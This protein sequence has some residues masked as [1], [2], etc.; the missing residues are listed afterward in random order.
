MTALRLV[1]RGAPEQ[2]L[3][4]SV[5]TPD[6]LAGLDGGA[7][8]RL[9]LQTTRHGVTVG[10][11]FRVHPGDA[12]EVVIEGG[13]DRFDL[14]GAAMRTGVLVVEG[15]VGQQAGRLMAGGRLEVRGAACGWAGSGL[16]GGVLE[17]GGNAG[18][19]LGGPLAGERTGMR[20]GVVLVRGRAGARAADR[21]RRGLVIV[22]GDAG[23]QAG[24]GMVAGTLVVCGAAG[25][26]PGILMR[27]GTIVLG[28]AVE[29]APSFVESGSVGLV[30]SRLLALAVAAMSERAGACVRSAGS[31]YLG[32]MAA[33]GKGE[34]LVAV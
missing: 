27:R 3:D 32:D 15:D 5:L 30:F 26:L 34:V 8:E 24:S 6:R 4:F 10:D 25:A 21:L 16:R 11:L 31:R 23:A 29:L 7:I 2:R 28:T 1:L 22:E 19:F 33:L 18:D 13:S 14:V 12:A 20:G 17:I 9:P